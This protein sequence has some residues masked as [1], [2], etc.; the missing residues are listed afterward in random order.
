MARL[1]INWFRI[2]FHNSSKK[3]AAFYVRQAFKFL[4]RIHPMDCGSRLMNVAALQFINSGSVVDSKLV[5]E[6]I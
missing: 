6:R 2:S 4:Q 5:G 3:L 1:S